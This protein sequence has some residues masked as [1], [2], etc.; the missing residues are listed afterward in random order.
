[1]DPFSW[2]LASLEFG[3]FKRKT[4]ETEEVGLTA[5]LRQR[6]RQEEDSDTDASE[7]KE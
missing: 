5:K 4:K 6:R 1:M 7:S 2:L 3:V